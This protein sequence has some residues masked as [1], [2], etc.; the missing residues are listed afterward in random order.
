VN[1]AAQH[2]VLVS[3]L[4]LPCLAAA[5][6]VRLPTPALRQPAQV[7]VAIPVGLAAGVCLAAVLGRG[8]VTRPAAALVAVLVVVGGSEEVLWRGFALARLAPAV[9]SVPALVLTTAGFAAS[10][11]PGLRGRGVLTHTVTGSVFGAVFIV[12]GSLAAAVAAHGSY[13]LLV[14][15]RRCPGPPA[16]AAASLRGVAKRF[17]V[18]RA[19]DG[20]DLTVGE[21][22]IVALLGPN[23]AG[24]TTAVS[25]LLGLSRPD[26]GTV[27]IFG[28]DPRIAAARGALGATPQDM[29][30]PPTLR[31]GEV[32]SFTGAHFQSPVPMHELLD[33]FGLTDIAR[34]QTGGLSGGQRRR[35]A[36]AVAFAGDPRLAILDE[37][38]TGLD[39]EA[40]HGLWDAIRAHAIRGRSVLLTTHHLEEAEALA[41]RIVVIVEGR[42]LAEG[43]PAHIRGSAST[44]EEGFLALVRRR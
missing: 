44:L 17:G 6:L 29:S 37:P 25:L 11:Y 27:E 38:T 21:G 7:A 8:R 28:R 3:L 5:L 31:V 20:L 2:R 42:K 24:K 14:V 35:L 43:S 40:R 36:T 4:A 9:G 41:H 39:V 19:L 34:R 16:A 22:E 18:V 33:T 12:T 1:V 30:F 32:V 13:N 23:G 15:A 10:H 26:R